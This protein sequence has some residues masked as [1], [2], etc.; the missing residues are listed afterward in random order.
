MQEIV[1]VLRLPSPAPRPQSLAFDGTSLW[2]GSRETRRIYALDPQHWTVRDE[3]VAPGIPYG[4]TVVG[5]ELRVLC[6]EGEE[7]HRVIRRFVPGHGFKSEGAIACPD[8]T[9]SQL[10]FDGDRLYVSQFYK[11]RVLSLDERGTVGSVVDVPHDICG[12]VVVAGRFFSITTDD[13]ET[14][15][16]WLTSVDARGAKAQVADVARLRFAARALAFDGTNFWTNHRERDEIV[17]FAA[18]WTL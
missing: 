13:E 18:P 7:D 16:Y 15:E 6:S 10:A 12:L 4:I 17:A 3:A 14:D 1:E 2:M 8:D 11:R 9:G 5:D